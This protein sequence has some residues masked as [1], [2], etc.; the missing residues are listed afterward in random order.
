M[1][2][3]RTKNWPLLY[4][5]NIF[6]GLSC[7]SFFSMPHV[8]F[9]ILLVTSC[10]FKNN[11]KKLNIAL[12]VALWI[13]AEIRKKYSPNHTDICLQRIHTSSEEKFCQCNEYNVYS[14]HNSTCLFW[15]L[16]PALILTHCNSCAIFNFYP[17]T[18]FMWKHL[19]W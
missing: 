7:S 19:V 17:F 13:A 15:I 10:I 14:F 1:C 12:W 5:L 6:W 18:H 2:I 11:L 4:W 9:L 3:N 8:I 16:T